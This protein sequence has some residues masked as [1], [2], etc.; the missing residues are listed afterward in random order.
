MKRI[1][2]VRAAVRRFRHL[3]VRT[4]ARHLINTHG[5]MFG[6]DLEKARSAVRTVMGR[7][8]E[9]IRNSTHPDDFQLGERDIKMPVTWI[10]RKPAYTLPAGLWGILADVHIPFHEPQPLAAA[11][12]YFEAQQVT[13]LL[14]N[15]D[16]FDCSAVGFWPN[17][18]RDFN[19]ELESFIDFLDI[20]RYRFADKPIVYKPGNHEYR[21]PRYFVSQAPDLAESP[22]A[23]M[24][25][26]CGFEERNITFLDYF[27]K[28]YAGKLP[29][30]HGHEMRTIDRAVNPARGLFLKA[31]TFAACSHCHSTSEHTARD[32]NGE[33]ITTWSTGC[34]CDL[35]PDYNPYG[36]NWNWGF[37]LVNVDK[38]GGFE[39][40]NRRVMP[41]GK[42]K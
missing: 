33:I 25:T 5:D 21:L 36:N 3:P 41:S 24:E 26:V 9:V 38:S 20:L 42:V 40:E 29:I 32:L 13:G 12:E 18:H 4:I 23:A 37:A 39:F 10:K 6:G 30:I 28:V 16:M 15:G 7:N 35:E 22:L 19:A 17:A 1:D 27:Q 34:L 31:K 14:L 11:I 8:G 2:I